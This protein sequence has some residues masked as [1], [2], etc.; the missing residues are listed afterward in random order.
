MTCLQARRPS[1]TDLSYEGGAAIVG[2][3]L[4][5]ERILASVRRD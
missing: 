4:A 5:V 2:T 3:G 1:Q